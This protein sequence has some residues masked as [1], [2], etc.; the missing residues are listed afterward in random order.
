MWPGPLWRS[1]P[2]LRLIGVNPMLH[3]MVAFD[4][5]VVCG[6]TGV[7]QIV[8]RDVWRYRQARVPSQSFVL[9]QNLLIVSW[10]CPFKYQYAF[11]AR[12]V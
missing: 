6:L 1:M 3:V 5:C 9:C 10:V 11:D 12:K 8:P 7:I 4:A 2:V